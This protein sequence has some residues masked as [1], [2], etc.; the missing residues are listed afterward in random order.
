[1]HPTP[2][3]SKHKHQVGIHFYGNLFLTTVSGTEDALGSTVGPSFSREIGAVNTFAM[4][5]KA[6]HIVNVIKGMIL[7]SVVNL[8]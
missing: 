4:I 6:I 7:R 3:E 2:R 5:M 1:M 8:L